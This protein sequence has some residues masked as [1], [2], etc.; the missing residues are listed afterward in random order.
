MSFGEILFLAIVIFACV[1]I[2]KWVRNIG[3]SAEKAA[4]LAVKN[5]HFG[6]VVQ[7]VENGAINGGDMEKIQGEVKVLAERNS[8]SA[9]LVKQAAD[10]GLQ[11]AMERILDDH[12]LTEE[13]ERNIRAAVDSFASLEFSP[14]A[15]DLMEKGRIMR[16]VAENRPEE[17]D[18]H[19][20]FNLQKSETLLY[21]FDY[22]E[23]HIEKTK[24]RYVGGS[25]GVSLRVA[26]GVYYH[27]GKHKGRREQD[28]T[29]EHEDDG[30]LGLTTKHI[31]FA[32][33]KRG[34]RIPYR[35]I[36]SLTTDSD[37]VQ[38]HRE[39]ASAKPQIFVHG[40]PNAGWFISN[41]ASHCS[42]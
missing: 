31:Y 17:Y 12:M 18:G 24:T 33:E 27:L 5:P 21:V 34:L 26:K 19:A 20:P 9:D 35:K 30:V 25:Q 37:S 6:A 39:G 4:K 22:V 11:K 28:T 14:I 41:I 7:L 23:Y 40:D 15:L 2:Y 32:G 13:E 3:S 16:L 36:V 10:H 38:I 42:D 1:K 29:V 8:L